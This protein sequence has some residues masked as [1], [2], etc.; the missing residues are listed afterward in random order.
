MQLS[1]PT[2][3]DW[4]WQGYDFISSFNIMRISQVWRQTAASTKVVFDRSKH[5]SDLG[6]TQ[7]LLSGDLPLDI[8][9]KVSSD[10][11]FGK[12]TAKLLREH[13]ARF[14][15]LEIQV[16]SHET[17]ETLV[18][19]IGEHKSAPLLERLTIH[20]EQA[21][22]ESQ[23]DT[24]TSLPTAFYPCPRL[25]HLTIRGAPLP[26][27]SAPHFRGLTSLTIDASDISCH[28][29]D[30]P[31]ILNILKS[32][33]NLQ[34]FSYLGSDL[35]NYHRRIIRSF[36][37]PHLISLNVSAPGCGL[38]IFRR[39]HAPLLTSVRFNGWRSEGW[40]EVWMDTLREPTSNSLR[41]LAERSPNVTH[42][43]LRSLELYNQPEDYG[44]LLS[45]YAFPRLKVL[46]LYAADIIDGYLAL[47]AG[48][49]KSLKR[50]ELLACGGVSADGVLKFTKGRKQ[51][52]ELLIDACPGIELED[53]TELKKTIKVL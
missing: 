50:L 35:F 40:S 17:V 33:E 8:Q 23:P 38:D 10:V 49:M 42:L 32:T 3:C 45:D 16:P 13:V 39:L 46:R 5:F 15:S 36:L 53:L 47:G 41:L 52:F 22:S 29:V 43:E 28:L 25:T 1:I 34:H 14:K 4:I 2:S 6:R 51:D 24:F 19:L 44:R 11:E 26:V 21:D 18:S 30:V 12:Q 27:S 9:I 37:M 20:A 7:T 31:R 48:R